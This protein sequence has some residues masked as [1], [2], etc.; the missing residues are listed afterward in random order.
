LHDWGLI[1]GSGRKGV[2]SLCHHLRTGSEAHPGP[3]PTCTMTSFSLGLKQLESES[4]YSP[5]TS[6]KVNN[7]GNYTSIS[8]YVFIAWNLV[9]QRDIF[10]LFDQ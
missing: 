10:T 4:D 5:P 2:S 6:A 7:A 9:M 1:P 3:Y 8:Q